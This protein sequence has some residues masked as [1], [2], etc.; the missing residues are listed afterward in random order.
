MTKKGKGNT[1]FAGARVERILRNAG[2]VRVSSEAIKALD[3]ALSAK[4]TAIAKRA[5]SIAKNAGRKTVSADD[6]D[7]AARG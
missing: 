2:A 7:I 6:I 1:T 4:G 3:G 5:A